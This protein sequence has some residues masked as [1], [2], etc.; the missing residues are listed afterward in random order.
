MIGPAAV[1]VLNTMRVPLMS[2]LILFS[3]PLILILALVVFTVPFN[4]VTLIHRGHDLTLRHGLIS[5]LPYKNAPF[6]WLLPGIAG[7]V[8]LAPQ[9]LAQAL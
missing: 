1:K 9:R 3:A 5:P 8:R 6:G 4:A 2:V 7:G